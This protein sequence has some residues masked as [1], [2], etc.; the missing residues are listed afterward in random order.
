MLVTTGGAGSWDVIDS[1]LGDLA[2]PRMVRVKQNFVHP[3]PIDVP[4]RV[5]GQLEDPSWWEALHPGDSVAIAVGSRGIENQV[6]AV[7]TIVA[8]IS[9]RGGLPFLI[10]AMGSHAG[11]TAEGQTAMLQGMGFTEENVG[12]PIRAT[13]DTVELGRT[14]EEDLPVLTDRLGY[15]ADHLV[16]INRIKPHVCFRGKYESGLMKMITIGLGKQKGA[17][18]AH[19]LGFGHMPDHVPMIAIEALKK[20]K[21]LFAVALVENGFHET[22][23]AEVMHGSSIADREPELLALAKQYSPTLHLKGFDVLIID[24]IGK[25][26]AGSGFDTNVVGRYHSDWIT[27]GPV[28]KRVAILDISKESKGNGNGLGMADF[29]TVRAVEKFDFSQTYPNTLT[30]LLTGGVKIPMVLPNDRQAYQACM[31]TSS[32]ANWEDTT[33]VRIHNTLCLTD[34]EVSENLLPQI[35]SDPRFEIVGQPYDLHFDAFGN[36]F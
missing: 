9:R 15:E 34:I 32:N 26:I 18:I 11:A 5:A 24:E 7:R 23:I 28:I 4:A 16:I 27:G 20:L 2:I 35:A 14:A 13:M 10:P 17:E 22:C 29:T 12:A 8:S 1:L 30:A 36:L 6:A 19:N 33:F 25:N 3:E 31:K 21:V